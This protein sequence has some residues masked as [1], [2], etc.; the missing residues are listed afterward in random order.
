VGNAR[1]ADQAD[2]RRREVG[3]VGKLRAGRAPSEGRVRRPDG[4]RRHRLSAS[5]RGTTA[6]HSLR[7]RGGDRRKPL[8]PHRFQRSQDPARRAVEIGAQL[9]EGPVRPRVDDVAPKRVRTGR[10]LQHKLRLLGGP[11]FGRSDGVGLQGSGDTEALVRRSNLD[12]QHPRRARQCGRR[13]GLRYCLPLGPLPRRGDRRQPVG[14]GKDRSAGIHR[15]RLGDLVVRR[16]PAPVPQAPHVRRSC[17]RF[18]DGLRLALDGLG[19]PQ[20][21][22]A[23]TGASPCSC[24]S[25]CPRPEAP[26]GCS[27]AM[28]ARFRRRR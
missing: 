24:R 6:G 22:I 19:E 11:G 5:P 26:F 3:P 27:G 9:V 14:S 20:S 7:R 25:Q 17:G 4:C 8:R 21:G 13:G 12:D 18:A 15:L 1:R 16:S 23:S 2:R 28:V 10:R